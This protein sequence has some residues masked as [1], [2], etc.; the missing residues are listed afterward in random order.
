MKT[1]QQLVGAQGVSNAK[2]TIAQIFA[3]TLPIYG[4]F[5]VDFEFPALH[6]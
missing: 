1:T 4:V 2:T 6:L 5:G 3:C